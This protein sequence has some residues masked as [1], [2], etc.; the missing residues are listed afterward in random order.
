MEE[1]N[2]ND[3]DRLRRLEEYV[4]YNHRFIA[5]TGGDK[6]Y[7]MKYFINLPLIG[8]SGLEIDLVSTSPST[9]V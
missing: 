6:K 1:D 3:A 4:D 5:D 7:A 2:P 8:E 9:L